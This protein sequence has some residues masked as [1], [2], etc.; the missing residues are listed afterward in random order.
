MR[1]MEGVEL[2]DRTGRADSEAAESIV[3]MLAST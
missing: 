3:A 2:L 1:R